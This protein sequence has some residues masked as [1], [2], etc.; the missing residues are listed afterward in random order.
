MAEKFILV[1]TIGGE[2]MSM[3]R[4][5][6][7]YALRQAEKLLR[8]HGCW[9]WWSALL[10]GSTAVEGLPRIGK[11][12]IARRSHSCASPQSASCSENFVI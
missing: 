8:E 6:Q 3:P 11:T 7:D 1:W 5:T 10:L 4:S 9:R 2:T 12:S